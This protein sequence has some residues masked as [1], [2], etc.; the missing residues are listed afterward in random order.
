VRKCL[1][2]IL[3][4]YSFGLYLYKEIDAKDSKILVKL[5]TGVVS[6]AVSPK[7]MSHLLFPIIDFYSG[8][9]S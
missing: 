1:A 6:I 3:S 7:K 8:F 2:Q 4:G 9:E 5:T